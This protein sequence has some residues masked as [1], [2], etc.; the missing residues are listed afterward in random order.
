MK[1]IDKF[2]YYFPSHIYFL[3][4]HNGLSGRSRTRI[5]TVYRAPVL[6]IQSWLTKTQ[7]LAGYIKSNLF[8][9]KHGYCRFPFLKFR[10][11]IFF[12]RFFS[13]DLMVLIK[14]CLTFE[15][16]QGLSCKF[17]PAQAR[18]YPKLLTASGTQ[19]NDLHSCRLRLGS[20]CGERAHTNVRMPN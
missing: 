18:S 14:F 6:G 11:T 3:T 2:H 16:P 20:A 19:S 13:F 9:S 15:M 4:K 1:I 7:L 5:W 8:R 10:S 12:S 17:L